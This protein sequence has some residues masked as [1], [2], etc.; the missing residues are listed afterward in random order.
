MTKGSR[1]SLFW[2]PRILAIAFA[3]F[4]SAFAVDVLGEGYTGWELLLALAIHLI[5]TAILAVVLVLAWR[6]EWVGTVL[7]AALGTFYVLSNPRHINWI[8]TISG[9]LFLIAALFLINWLKR[10]ELHPRA[11]HAEP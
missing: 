5:P 2:A 7:F 4:V 11:H 1:L 3:L 8:F 10:A 6:W 9:P